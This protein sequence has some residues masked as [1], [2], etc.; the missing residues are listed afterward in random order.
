MPLLNKSHVICPECPNGCNISLLPDDE[1]ALIIEGNKCEKGLHFIRKAADK[2]GI[3]RKVI[4]KSKLSRYSTSFLKEIAASFNIDLKEIHPRYDMGGSPERTVF[5]IVIEDMNSKLFI[6]EE[7]PYSSIK[8]KQNIALTLDFLDKEGLPYINPF[9][10][11]AVKK[12][13]FEHKNSFW[14]TEPFIAGAKL[15]REKYVFDGWRAEF[16]SGF[17]VKLKAKSKSIPHLDKNEVFSITEYILKLKGQIKINNPAIVPMIEPI[18]SFLEE[19]FFAAHENL[20]VALCHGDYHP[21]NIIWSE[22]GIKA[23]I[24]WEF[25]GFKPEI[26]DLAN[27]IGCLGV[28]NP[29]SLTGKLVMLLIGRIRSENLYSDIS[30]NLLV[31]FILAIRFAWLSE[32]LRKE[33][34]QMVSLEID[35]MNLLMDNRK[36]FIEAWGISG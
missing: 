20:P 29:K 27:L 32:W 22:K 30:L 28:E 25:H 35:Y 12:H 11:T 19:G 10:K 31:E 36:Y 33:D 16:L 4:S 15:D 9:L 14:Q 23:V 26:Y 21:M 1:G 2:E 24:D 8:K 17:L 5:R 3:K 34:A 6:L 7:I 13:I 18:I